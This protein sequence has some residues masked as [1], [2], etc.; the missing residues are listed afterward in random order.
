MTS[1]CR[2]LCLGLALISL[3]VASLAAGGQAA[4]TSQPSAAWTPPRAADGHPSL[5]GVWENNSATPLERPAHLK[6]KPRLTDQELADMERRAKAVFS[7]EDEPRSVTPCIK[8]CS[9]TGRQQDWA[10]PARIVRTG[11]QTGISSTAPR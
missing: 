1:V 3:P 6:D 2:R 8:R 7:P 11:C 9:P 5:E 10:P 4:R